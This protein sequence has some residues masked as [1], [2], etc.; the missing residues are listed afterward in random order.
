MFIDKEYFNAGIDRILDRIDSLESRLVKPEKTRYRINGEQLLDNQD[1]C[2]MLS[3]SKRTLQRYRSSGKLKYRRIDQK[4]YYLESDVQDFI[5]EN[6]KAV[7]R[8]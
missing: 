6:L 3:I 2:F 4:T 8:K 7:S 5:R 1:L